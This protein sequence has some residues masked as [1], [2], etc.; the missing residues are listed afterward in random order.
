MPDTERIIRIVAAVVRDDAGR[1]LV[2]RKKG[3]T[4]FMQPGGKIEP[5]EGLEDALRREVREELSVGIAESHSLGRFTAEAAHEPGFTVEAELFDVTL[6]GEPRKAAEI[7]EMRW[8]GL[9]EAA[10][11]PIAELSRKAVF[12][13]LGG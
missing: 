9:D 5:G 6:A 7:E 2:V 11:L 4:V 1:V 13:R 12:E 3:T 8:V 10:A